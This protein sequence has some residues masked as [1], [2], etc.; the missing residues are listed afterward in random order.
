M[1]A[2]EVYVDPWGSI[3]L[4]V[5]SFWMKPYINIDCQL[6]KGRRESKCY[7]LGVGEYLYGP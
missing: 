6:K 5:A 1:K 3:V 4:G 2:Q 7:L